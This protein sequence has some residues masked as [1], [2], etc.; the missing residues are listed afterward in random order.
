MFDRDRLPGLSS[1]CT[2]KAETRP[3]TCKACCCSEATVVVC[4]WMALFAHHAVCKAAL[5]EAYSPITSVLQ[6]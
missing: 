4:R 1:C 5:P 6:L 3:I 2:T